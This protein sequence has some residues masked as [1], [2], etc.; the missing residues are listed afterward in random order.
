MG[1]KGILQFRKSIEKYKYVFWILLIGIMLMLLP[2]GKPSIAQPDVAAAKE[3]RTEREPLQDQL[4]ALLCQLADA[5][6]VRVLLT[7]AVGSQTIY[8]TDSDASHEN[9]V[10]VSDNTRNQTGLIRQIAPPT[11]LGAVVLCQG[12]DKPAVRLAITEAVSNATGLGYNRI[13]VL[14]MK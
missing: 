14:K 1:Q 2:S 4:A 7:E 8:Q 10:I 11:Y 6:N 3:I 13:S 5:G 9:T 12:A